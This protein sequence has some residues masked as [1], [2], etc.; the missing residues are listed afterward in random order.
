MLTPYS[1]LIPHDHAANDIAL[2][3][4]TALARHTDL[5]V[6]APGQQCSGKESWRMDGVTYH[7]GSKVCPRQIDRLHRY[8]Y[9]ARGSWSR[10]S[11]DEA[12]AIAE[13]VNPDILHAEYV[14]T[15]E[16]LLRASRLAPTSL[17]L[18]DLPGEVAV[19]PRS[20]LSML[21]FWLQRLERAKTLRLRDA[22]LEQIDALFVF[23]DRDRRKIAGA[24]R[25]VEVAPLGVDPPPAGWAGDRAYVACFGGAMWRLEN[26]MTALYLAREVWPLVRA[27]LPDA[28]LRIF[29][30]RPG[31]RVLDLESSPGVT[32]IGEV[33]DYDDEFR[34]AAVTLAPAMVEAGI[35]MKA[36]R[37]MAMGCPV[38]LNPQ[39]AE[40]IVG[41][42]NGEHALIGENPAELAVRVIEL[43]RDPA[44]AS[45]LGQ[46][47]KELIRSH[48]SWD[49]TVDTYLS[50]WD[51]LLKRST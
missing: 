32:V 22:I 14:Q 15:A 51:Q 17:T 33:A 39:S 5:H 48:F 30:A 43:M 29:G 28:S 44:R 8:P 4:V 20:E 18:H 47:A 19:Q 46:A 40:P 42:Q 38:V 1:P 31:P 6:Y 41:L 10:T 16:P 3:L 9:A 35:L 45:D 2:P 12:I 11:T 7:A 49:R 21:R 24:G 50:V 13:V 27:E 36:I 34:H 25:I 23:N 37:A 26:E